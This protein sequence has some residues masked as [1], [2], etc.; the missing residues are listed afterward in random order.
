MQN[1]KEELTKQ[2]I[3]EAARMDDG[4]ISELIFAIPYLTEGKLSYEEIH[5]LYIKAKQNSS[6]NPHPE[7]E[8]VQCYE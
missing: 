7:D 8:Q 5:Q 4:E 2:L 6:Q 1:E 3:N